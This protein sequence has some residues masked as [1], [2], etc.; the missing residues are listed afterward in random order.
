[1]NDWPQPVPSRIPGTREPDVEIPVRGPSFAFVGEAPADGLLYLRNGQ[2]G[3]WTPETVAGPTEASS[4]IVNPPVEGASNAQGALQGLADA[5]TG[6]SSTGGGLL[7]VAVTSPLTGNGTPGSP[8]GMPTNLLSS[9]AVV[10]PLAGNGAS[11]TPIYLG[12][13]PISL[14]GTG[15]SSTLSARFNLGITPENIGAQP[16]GNYLIAVAR[17]SPLTGTGASSSPLAL[18]SYLTTEARLTSEPITFVFGGTPL[19]G[20]MINIPLTMNLSIPSN[21]SGSYYY[22]AVNPAS[23]SAFQLRVMPANTLIGTINVNASGVATFSGTGSTTL[24]AG[25]V[26]RMTAV[27]VG[28]DL[29]DVGITIQAT[30]R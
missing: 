7:S 18:P 21:L 29:T 25:N 26:L 8:I 17:T 30:R 2:T 10:S 12:I 14:G 24:T 15:A 4:V 5:V 1:M 22:N 6:L 3:Q 20:M 28:T 23:A 11:G 13:V 19:T 9:A 27:V 16:A